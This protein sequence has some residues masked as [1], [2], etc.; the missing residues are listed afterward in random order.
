MAPNRMSLGELAEVK[1]QVEDLLQKQFV[2][3]SVSPW[4]A[5]VLLVEQKDGTIRICVDYWQLNKVIIK[6]KYPLLKID[7]LMDQLRGAI[8]FSKIGLRSGYHQIRVKNENDYGRLYKG[9][10][11]DSM[12]EAEEC[13]RG[14]VDLVL[15]DPERK[16][17]VYCDAFG[18]GLRCVLMQ[19]GRVVAYVSRFEVFTD[20]KSLKYLFDQKKLNMRQR[21]WMKFLKD[22]N[23]TL[24]YHPGKENVVADTLSKKSL[25]VTAMMVEKMELIKEFRDMNLAMEV[26]P[27]SLYLVVTTIHNDFLVYVRDA[28]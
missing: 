19:D 4:G 14:E 21:R 5:S 17:D 8:V 6:N 2:R 27:K 22:Y 23:F 24:S 16:F 25:H 12:A 13:D 3:S 11:S 7:D 26:R 20:H 15:L 1:K 28:Q 10:S 9:G 18:H